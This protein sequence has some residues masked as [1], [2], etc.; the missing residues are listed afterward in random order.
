[1]PVVGKSEMWSELVTGR[2]DRAA[3]AVTISNTDAPYE[4]DQPART[5]ANNPFCMVQHLLE[6]VTNDTISVR[7]VTMNGIVHVACAHILNHAG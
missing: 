1:M 5:P 4:A 2:H 6:L 3:G 7:Q